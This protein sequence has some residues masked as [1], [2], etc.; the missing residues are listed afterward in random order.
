MSM[1]F[2]KDD[3]DWGAYMAATDAQ[4][5]V[6]PA[7]HWEA[8]LLDEF[9]PQADTSPHSRL[10]WSRLN[11]RIALRP[12]EVSL[13]FGFNGHGKSLLLGHAMLSVCAQRQRACIASFEMRPRKTL[14]RMARQWADSEAPKPAQVR[15]FVGWA[16]GRLWLYDQTGTV[17]AERVYAVIRYAV[18]KLKVQHFVLD[19]LT[20]CVAADDDYP[21]Q[22]RLVDQLTALAQEL[23]VHIHL[24]HHARKDRDETRPPRKM[25]ALGASAITNLVDNVFIVWRNKAKYEADEPKS[26]EPDAMLI[27]DKQR[28][29]TGWEGALNLFFH[30][31]SMQ[32][33]QVGTSAMNLAVWPHSA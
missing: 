14:A 24:V 13:W 15:E 18:D 16:Q 25:D 7:A 19:N 20:K 33:L 2:D 17:E 9:G 5:K 4:H 21:G 30:Q 27:C 29:G 32:Y 28:H 10:P 8:D 3:I 1:I 31:R 26:N 11:S 12:G 22:K 23:D 6:K